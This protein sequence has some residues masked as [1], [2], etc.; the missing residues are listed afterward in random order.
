M[1]IYVDPERA[2]QLREIG[3]QIGANTIKHTI[4][5]LIHYYHLEE[6]NKKKMPLETSIGKEVLKIV[7]SEKEIFYL[8]SVL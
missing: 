5:L 1:R 2:I 4:E 6:Y 8:N 7:E 3:K